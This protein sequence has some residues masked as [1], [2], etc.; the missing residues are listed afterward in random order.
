MKISEH[1]IAGA[2]YAGQ[3]CRQFSE[4]IAPSLRGDGTEQEKIYQAVKMCD[5]SIEAA[6][7]L[8]SEVV[9]ILREL[10]P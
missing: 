10:R 8:I 9:S 3:D 2:E 4:M 5:K 6:Y 7:R 1:L